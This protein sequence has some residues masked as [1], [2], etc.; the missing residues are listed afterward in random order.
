MPVWRRVGL[1]PLDQPEV[2]DLRRPVAGQEDVRRLDVAV[3]DPTAVGHVHGPGQRLDDPRRVLDGLRFA[4]D[5]LRQA[6][7]LEELQREIR[8]AVVLAD[9]EDLDD[10]GV[11]DGGDGAGLGLEAS[12]VVRSCTGAGLDHLQRDQALE[13]EV[14]RLVHDPHAAGAQHAQDLVAGDPRPF[15]ALAAVGRSGRLLRIPRRDTRRVH[16]ALGGIGVVVSRPIAV[17]AGRGVGIVMGG[18]VA[19][20]VRDRVAVEVRGIR[21]RGSSGRPAISDPPYD[22]R[23][24]AVSLIGPAPS[25]NE[26]SKSPPRSCSGLV[27]A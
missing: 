6:A 18:G 21:I 13:P 10:V 3:D 15:A 14:P 17:R 8:Q 20:E 4:G 5:P 23:P 1:Q 11:V 9:L 12:Q 16:E 26:G 19:V 22:G 25:A 2:G 27:G 24:G 7:S